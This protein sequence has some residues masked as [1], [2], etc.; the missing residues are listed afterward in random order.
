MMTMTFRSTGVFASLCLSHRDRKFMLLPPVQALPAHHPGVN[1]LARIIPKS[2]AP[3]PY[4]CRHTVAPTHLPA[5]ASSSLANPLERREP[6]PSR[7]ENGAVPLYEKSGVGFTFGA[8]YSSFFSSGGAGF[9]VDTYAAKSASFWS[10]QASGVPLSG[11]TMHALM[12][13]S[14][15]MTFPAI[16]QNLG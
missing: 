2:S 5:L 9:T 6:I 1:A 4:L 3:A 14:R 10:S 16:P 7:A 12:T 13:W 11:P 8:S 15:V